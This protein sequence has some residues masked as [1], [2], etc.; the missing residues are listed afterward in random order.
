MCSLHSWSEEK[1][2]GLLPYL[3]GQLKDPGFH[4]GPQFSRRVL[5]FVEVAVLVVA[6]LGD[7]G[8]LVD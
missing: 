5:T 7:Q 1:T 8:L 6:G 2:D 3:G 4:L